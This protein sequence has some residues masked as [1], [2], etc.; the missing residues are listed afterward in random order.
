MQQVV[1][2]NHC[3]VVSRFDYDKGKRTFQLYMHSRHSLGLKI[4]FQCIFVLF[5]RTHT[6][7]Y[8]LQFVKST[9]LMLLQNSKFSRFVCHS[10]IEFVFS[11]VSAHFALYRQL[12]NR[13]AT[14]I[15]YFK[16][17]YALQMSKSAS[18]RKSLSDLLSLLRFVKC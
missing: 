2:S 11:F 14:E 17:K 9:H 8:T 13:T 5:K 12:P 16:M 4:A 7:V 18:L 6:P 1:M 3:C 10:K 15:R